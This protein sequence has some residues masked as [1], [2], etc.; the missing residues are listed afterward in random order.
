MSLK[1]KLFALLLLFKSVDLNSCS[2]D[3]R[4]CTIYTGYTGPT[5]SKGSTGSTVSQSDL[6]AKT[7][8]PL[9]ELLYKSGAPYLK[10][11][12]FIDAAEAEARGLV[13]TREDAILKGFIAPSDAHKYHSGPLFAFLSISSPGIIR[14]IIT[15]KKFDPSQAHDYLEPKPIRPILN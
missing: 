8:L 7:Q 11:I 14:P 4:S 10:N 5:G 2:E 3:T 12:G 6:M 13:R 9:I 15:P 1:I